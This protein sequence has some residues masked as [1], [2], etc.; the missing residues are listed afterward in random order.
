MRKLA[1]KPVRSDAPRSLTIYGALTLVW[2]V[3]AIGFVVIMTLLFYDRMVAIAPE[4]VVWMVLGAF[5]LLLFVPVA[6]VFGRP[7]WERIRTRRKAVPR[8]A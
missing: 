2:L 6:L 7:A 3:A 4:E 1:G 8:A 5:Y